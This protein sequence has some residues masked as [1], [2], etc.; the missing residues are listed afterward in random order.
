MKTYTLKFKAM[1]LSVSLLAANQAY[2]DNNQFIYTTVGQIKDTVST[3]LNLTAN[4]LDR[5][6]KSNLSSVLQIGGQKLETIAANNRQ[7]KFQVD[8]AGGSSDRAILEALYEFSHMMAYQELLAFYNTLTSFKEVY[9][10]QKASETAAKKAIELLAVLKK[11]LDTYNSSGTIE[12]FERKLNEIYEL[13]ITADQTAAANELKTI[14]TMTQ[15]KIDE[16]KSKV[17]TSLATV[18]KPKMS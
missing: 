7:L 5:N 18:L 14:I 10:V 12:K 11:Q 2:A 8:R 9:L 3:L 6:D 15:A 16:I 4:L 17:G 13:L 1:A